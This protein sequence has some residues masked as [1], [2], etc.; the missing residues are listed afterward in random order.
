MLDRPLLTGVSRPPGGSDPTYF[1]QLERRIHD[2]VLQSLGVS[3]LGAELC[4]RL[5]AAGQQEEALH[6]LDEVVRETEAAIE[7]LR[8]IMCELHVGSAARDLGA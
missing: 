8:T 3:L 4:R 7:V 2:D 6:E 1:A 5:W